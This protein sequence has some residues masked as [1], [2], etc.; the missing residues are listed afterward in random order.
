MANLTK[1]QKVRLGLFVGTAVSVLAGATLLLAGR[2]LTE[3]RDTYRIRFSSKAA[4]FS[5]LSVGSDVT[6][7]GIKIG[8]VETL[9]VAPDDVSVIAVSISVT[10]GTPIAVDS[11]ASLG[12]QG[13]TGMKYV[14]ISRG[15]AKVRVRKPGELI[16]PGESMLDDLT[17]RAASIGDKLETLLVHLQDMTG[18]K[19][20]KSMQ[21][22]LDETAGL[23]ADNRANITAIIG[24]ARRA[25]DELA[26]LVQS[27]NTV[28]VHADKLVVDLGGVTG[29]LRR[30]VGPRGE[31]AQTLA[32]VDKLVDS[33]NM[34]ILRSQ[35]DIDV[36]LRHLRDAAA[37]MADFSLAVKENPTL[38]MFSSDRSSDRRIGK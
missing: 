30:T 11:K 17:A 21:E 34:V 16:P 9:A 23:I 22:I 37:D 8:R 27:V 36:T 4:S 3:Q 38:L 18:V 29:E 31:A 14:D 7:S 26:N 1:G 35:G 20:Q 6:Y 2:A 33:L 12:S 28:V 19:A 25:S 32:K 5:G 10:H 24:N 13:I 15:S